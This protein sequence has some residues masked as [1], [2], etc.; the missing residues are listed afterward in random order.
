MLEFQP[1]II[2]IMLGANDA[3]DFNWNGVQRQGIETYEADY[4]DLVEMLQQL[5]T[6]PKVCCH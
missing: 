3:R 5:P 1:H 6:H 4:V 2:T